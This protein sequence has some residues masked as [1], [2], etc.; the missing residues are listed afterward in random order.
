MTAYGRIEPATRQAAPDV[1]RAPLILLAA[2]SL[3]ILLLFWRDV[4]DIAAIWWNSST[5][6]HCLLILPIIGWLVWQRRQEL[7][8]LTPQASMAGLSVAALGALAWML[9]EAASV[10]LGRHLGIVL[11]LQGA[12]VSILG[13]TVA[14]GLLFPLFYAF[15]LVPFGE[16]FVPALQMVTAELSMVLLSLVGLPAHIEGVFITTPSGYFEVAEAC[17]GV[18]FLIAMVALGALTA[19]LCFRSWPRRIA[20]MG[21]CIAIPIIANG[22]R[23]FGTIYIADISGIEFAESFDHV[24]YGWIFFGTGITLV[25]AIGWR[26]FDRDIDAPA[27]DPAAFRTDR[28]RGQPAF[29]TGGIVTA[30]AIAPVLWMASGSNDPDAVGAVA[31]PEI[32]GWQHTDSA[33]AYPWTAT[34]EGADRLVSGRY[35]SNGQ[36]VDL[37]IGYFRDQQDGRELVGFGQGGLPVDTE[38]SWVEDSAPLGGG[39]AYR[40]AA[41]GPVYREIVQHSLIGDVITGS[42]SRAK[43]ETMRVRLLGGDSRA[44]GVVISAEGRNTRAAIE[45]FLGA[46]GGAE[47][48]VDRALVMPD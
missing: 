15:F 19:N 44:I 1:W 8:Q 6:N 22:I 34:Y 35:T 33:M 40:I 25:L 31:L 5:F 13:I 10:G 47:A 29:L 11:M 7:A 27:F 42:D 28:G 18:K 46:A 17:S 26:F 36:T 32:A 39:R 37:A 3:S 16:E 21:V 2:V 48:L 23:A 12:T 9:G 14:R 43:L 45:A 30:L 38:W 24:F 41:P 4:A 20:F